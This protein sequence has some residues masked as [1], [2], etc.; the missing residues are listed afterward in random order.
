MILTRAPLRIPLGG[1][2]T[3][4]PSYYL[5]HGGFV[6]GFALANY[7]YVVLHKTL[8]RKIRVKYSKAECVDDVE[9]LENRVAAEALKAYGITDSIEIATFS[10]VPEGSGLG[11]SSSFCVALVLALRKLL[12][13]NMDR[14]EIHASAYDIERNRAGVPGG[15]QDQFFASLGGAWTLELGDSF[16]QEALDIGDLP[17]MLKLVYTGSPRMNLDIAHNQISKTS[18]GDSSM[19]KS[20]D[21]VKGLGKEIAIA[22]R[23]GDYEHVGELFH[24]HWLSKLS[25]DPD[26]ASPAVKA[27]YDSFRHN[28]VLGGKLIGLGGG[29]YFLL[30]AP[31]GCLADVPHMNV[32][33]DFEGC[34]VVYCS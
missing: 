9:A 17:S 22:I 6:C 20:L 1:G 5:R 11:G 32:V 16:K 26:I 13:L 25:R 8:D 7:V 2:G 3:D 4:F 23:D 24:I 29:G 31:N 33:P 28:G 21:A 27:A 12:G 34:K 30:Y 19:Q 10:D 18:N 15:L 14:Y